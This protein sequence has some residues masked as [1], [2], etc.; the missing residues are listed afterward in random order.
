MWGMQREHHHEHT[1]P[2][3]EVEAAPIAHEAESRTAFTSHGELPPV[4][5]ESS[6]TGTSASER[7]FGG[8]EA[9][10]ARAAS[11]HG[12]P[13]GDRNV[14]MDHINKHHKGWDSTHT[15]RQAT[16][17][18]IGE[19][20]HTPKLK[21]SSASVYDTNHERDKGRAP[22]FTNDGKLHGHLSPGDSIPI[23]AGQIAHL[24]LEGYAHDVPCVLGHGS[25]PG[26]IPAAY[27]EHHDQLE[28]VQ[29]DLS[30][31][32]NHARHTAQDA[33]HGHAAKTITANAIP[34][35]TDTLFTKPHEVGDANHAHDYF[36][37]DGNRV[38]LLINIP[39]WGHDGERFGAASDVV[40]AVPPG[41]KDADVPRES[42]F[43][44]TGQH[45]SSPLYKHLKTNVEGHIHFT[46]GYVV[47]NAGEKRFGWINS[48]LLS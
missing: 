34:A 4:A 25:T 41:T 33:D 26:W 39:T 12:I 31:S 16:R 36:L 28:H 17:V 10:Q 14:A 11:S 19:H 3:H 20:G 18:G 22:V 1:A 30:K 40:Q 7:A 27:F 38:N 21:A 48:H 47:N 45:A 9:V 2:N 23:N 37:R 5:T 44:P 35:H 42:K 43:H 8:G 13:G 32:L 6:V 24:K 29:H 15:H 46:Y